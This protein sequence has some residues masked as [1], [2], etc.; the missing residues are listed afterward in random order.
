ME[1]DFVK[2]SAEFLNRHIREVLA[3]EHKEM[4]VTFVTYSHYCDVEDIYSAAY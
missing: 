3:D 2:G 4:E 1:Y